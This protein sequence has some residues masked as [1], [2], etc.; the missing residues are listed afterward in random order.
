MT[1]APAILALDYSHETFY[2]DVQLQSLPGKRQPD[3]QSN[4]VYPFC[5]KG[6][7]YIC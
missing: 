2:G 3:I 6:K 1:Q 5:G 4:T 7:L